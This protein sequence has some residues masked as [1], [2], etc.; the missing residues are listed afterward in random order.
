MNLK[1]KK[2]T[3]ESGTIEIHENGYILMEHK[4]NSR[5][6]INELIKR[7]NAIID[8]CQG[9]KYPILIDTRNKFIDFDTK[10]R[11]HTDNNKVVD[12]LILAEAFIVNNL[13][14]KLLIQDHMANNSGE[15]PIE[16]FSSKQDAVNWITQFIRKP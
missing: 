12:H 10:A 8:L 5:I 13:G 2:K 11:H 6:C 4:N 9:E 7:E 3:L 15:F 14:V 16:I 1:L